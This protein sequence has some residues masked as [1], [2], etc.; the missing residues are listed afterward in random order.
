VRSPNGNWAAISAAICLMISLSMANTNPQQ[1]YGTVVL[2][3]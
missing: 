2:V 1:R 3:A